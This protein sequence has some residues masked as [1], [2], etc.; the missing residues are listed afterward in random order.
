VKDK[1]VTI[2]ANTPVGNILLT[3]VSYDY[4]KRIAAHYENMTYEQQVLDV[5][6]E[7]DFTHFLDV[8]S[9]FGY[10]ALAAAAKDNVKA[11][12]AYE[13][14]PIRYGLLWWNTHNHPKITPRME[15]VGSDVTMKTVAISDN[16][17]GL[18]GM[19]VGQ[20]KALSEE[21]HRLMPTT[22]LDNTFTFLRMTTK[23]PL[24]VLTKI[25]VEGFELDVL[26]GAQKLFI[27]GNYF[28]IETHKSVI[29]D[30]DVLAYMTARG[31]GSYKPLI[32]TQK[33]STYLF[34]S[35]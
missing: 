6:R 7:L 12:W 33:N 25:D 21:E 10:F 26:A 5:V 4:T 27:P 2:E 30:D 14:H 18:F 1:F 22:T 32:N 11:V 29:K 19:E 28:I 3:D 23:E 31:F 8:G 35:G 24:N 13:P 20:R 16:P 34:R 17:S 15:F 9:A